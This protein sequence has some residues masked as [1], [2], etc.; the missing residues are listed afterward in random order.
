MDEHYNSL[1]SLE[2]LTIGDMERPALDDRSYKVIT[3]SNK[4][5]ALLIRDADTDKASAA[6]DVNVG[7]F[8]DAKDL[9]GTAHAVEHLLFM[10][11]EKYPKENE[12]HQYLTSH[13]GHSNA[14]TAGTSTNYYFEV[15]A[16]SSKTSTPTPAD[17]EATNDSPLYGALDRFAQ[18]F[19][20]PLF[21]EDTLD[22]ELR[23]VDSENKKNLQSDN[24]RLHQLHKSLSNPA[25]PYCHFSTGNYQTLHDEPL[26]RGV[27]IRDEFIKFYDTH[28]SANRM[29]L[30]VLGRE[31]LEQLEAWVQELF[32]PVKNKDLPRNRWDGVPLYTDKELLTQLFAK[33]VCDMKT[34]DI[35]FPY[36]DEEQYY[37]SQPSHYLGHLI[38]Y[39]GPGSILAYLKGKGWVTG[40]G[41]GASSLCPGSS[42]YS[43]T[44]KLTEEGIK[45]YQ[46][47]TEVVFQ[48]IAMLRE[49]PPQQQYHEELKKMSEVNF[50]FKQ[51]SPASKTTSRLSAVM[52]R[53]YPRDRLLS[54]PSLVRKFEPEAIKK[55]L[56][57]LSPDNFR[58]IITSQDFPGDWDQKEK[59]YGTEYRYERIP[60]EF[61]QRIVKAAN[62]GSKERVPELHLPHSNEF[63][64]TRLEV[65]KREVEKPLKAPKLLRN[66][67][68]VRVWFKKDDQFWV[69]KANLYVTLRTPHVS[70]TPRNSMLT[71]LYHALVQDALNEYAYDAEVAGLDYYISSNSTG[72]SVHLVGYN[73]KMA[74]LLEK[75]M[76]SMKELEVRDDRFVVIKERLLRTYKNWEFQ[77]PYYQVG[78]YSRWLTSEAGW[79]NEQYL[80]ELQH[81]SAEEVRSFFPQLIHQMHIETF[82]HGNVH[83][84][85]ALRFTDLVESILR[86]RKY[87]PS[88]WRVQRS[89][90]LP[91]GSNFVYERF[92]KDPANINHCIEYNLYVGDYCDRVL[93]AKATLF[94]QIAD[95][96]CF[97]QLRTKEQL[98]YVVFSGVRMGSASIRWRVLV[99]S[100]KHPKYLE[101]RIDAFL[102]ALGKQL[103]EMTPEKF[104]KH[105][106]SLINKH[107]ERDKN[108][109]QESGRLWGHITCEYFDFEIQDT[110][111]CHIEQTT[112]EEIV[113]FFEQYISPESSE[114]AKLSV[115]LLAQGLPH[116]IAVDDKLPKPIPELLNLLTKF[117]DTQGIK[118]DSELLKQRLHS[119]NAEG[120]NLEP[121][122]R[123]VLSY[124]V[125]DAKVPEEQAKDVMT[126]ALALIPEAKEENL[127]EGTAKTAVPITDV[128]SFKASLPVSH[129]PQPVKDLSEFEDIEAK[130]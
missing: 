111:V 36:P 82:A 28:Y 109:S 25:H 43:I 74:V 75:V 87:P 108:L 68:L 56:E 26:A 125:E 126:Q 116:T 48:Y 49:A 5:E 24:W 18:F 79:I 92:L 81:I 27:R 52:Q 50:R 86:P 85:D 114:R 80:A 34:L 96:P 110:N 118:V 1:P 47:I 98:G 129:G 64:P 21:L 60:D 13:S 38:G 100:E 23:A 42:Y 46:E 53:P 107:L 88:Q 104:Q 63:I 33:P 9:P 14:Y 4:L 119:V 127:T 7:S 99:Q 69:P 8:S 40:L 44:I 90:I 115:H 57:Y 83:R 32:A 130:L 112:Q 77:L 94:G 113:Q 70:T 30:V 3:L 76:R 73:D 117:F 128:R 37:E 31:S 22:R 11:T 62:A 61:L 15:A 120:Q 121:M 51:K 66:D 20:K 2:R 103:K 93:K 29:K 106:T 58:I 54:G 45:H 122:A 71:Q 59:W 41:A 97:D 102:A 89:L 39:E 17:A 35:Y 65:E 101:G 123:A 12:Y 84:E 55:G 67:D 105:K 16:S 19:I 78:N 10:G 72:L 95:E 124:L 91:P 6:L